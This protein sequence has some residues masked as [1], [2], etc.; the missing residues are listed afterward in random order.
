MI[1]APQKKLVIKEER[2]LL[3]LKMSCSIFLKILLIEREGERE[4]MSR[5]GEKRQ[6]ESNRQI[7]H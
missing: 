2:V 5:E 6:K 4:S 3:H 7:P 1:S